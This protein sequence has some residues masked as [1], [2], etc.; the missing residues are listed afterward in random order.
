MQIIRLQLKHFRCFADVTFSFEKPIIVIE[1][2]N[3]SGKTSLLEALHYL[4]YLRS[5]RTYWPRELMQF[6]QQNFFIKAKFADEVGPHEL[7]VGFTDKKRLVKLD[8]KAITSYKQLMDHYRIITI[9]EDELGLIKEGPEIR[10]NFLDQAI[11]LFKPDF[12]LT[13]RKLRKLV[14][15]RN[16]LLKKGHFTQESYQLWTQQ[17]WQHSKTIQEERTKM[18][19]SL[20]R[21]TRKLLKTHF[22]SLSIAFDYKPKRISKDDNSI[23]SFLA[24]NSQLQHDEARYG[25]SLFGA[26]LD[27]FS[28]IFQDK[29]SR[30]F[31]SRGQQKLIVLL[32]N[33]AYAQQLI[34]KRGSVIMLIDDFMTDFDQSRCTLLVDI[35]HQLGCQLI[36]TLPSRHNFLVEQL[37]GLGAQ[38]IK[39]PN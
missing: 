39:L 19:N 35:L 21:S 4:C 9:T 6:E 3:G 27:D 1:G 26:H 31:A 18:L 24:K 36:F 23:E 2:V 22:P 33:I 7:Q 32:I 15:Q 38:S 10:R 20:Q 8:K 17:L 25:R 28:I 12:L 11:A 37:T 34:K 16:A 14:E 30:N 29:R 5:F 13:I